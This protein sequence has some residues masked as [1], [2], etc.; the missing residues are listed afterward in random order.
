MARQRNAMRMAFHWWADSGLSWD[1]GW[2]L[3][4]DTLSLYFENHDKG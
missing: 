3:S 4:T 1:A 2:E